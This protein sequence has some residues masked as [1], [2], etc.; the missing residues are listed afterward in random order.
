LRKKRKEK[1][2]KEKETKEESRV[3]P[4]ARSLFLVILLLHLIYILS[5][6]IMLLSVS[7]VIKKLINK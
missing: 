2:R 1:K 3:L 4:Y 6:R 5:W 7:L